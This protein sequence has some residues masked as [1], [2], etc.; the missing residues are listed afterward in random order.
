[1]PPGVRITI[2]VVAL[3][4][5]IGFAATVFSSPDAFPNPGAIYGCAAFCL[6]IAVACLSG[7]IG[8]II[9]RGIA[10]LICLAYVWYIF[11]EFSAPAPVL[12]SGSRAKPD[13]VKSIAGFLLIGVPCGLYAVLGGRLIEW[14]RSINTK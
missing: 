2:A 5:G 6:L 10:G 1:M 9:R 14:F 13:I 8:E 11:K 12:L 3:L 4:C 7:P